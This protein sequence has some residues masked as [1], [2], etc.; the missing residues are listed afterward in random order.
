MRKF[1]VEVR[2]TLSRIVT[3]DAY[4]ELDAVDRVEELYWAVKIVLDEED[5]SGVRFYPTEVV[6][7][8]ESDKNDYK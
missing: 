4:N 7:D 8:E 5:Y 3:I 1:K 6:E 2:E